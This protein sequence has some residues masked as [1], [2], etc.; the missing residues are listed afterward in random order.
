M[1]IKPIERTSATIERK[2]ATI[3]RQPAS[4][5]R[6]KKLDISEIMEP[7]ESDIPEVDGDFLDQLEAETKAVVDSV[8]ADRAEFREFVAQLNDTKFYISVVFQSESQKIDFLQKAGLLDI[9]DQ[10]NYDNMFVSGLE[11]ARRLGYPVEPIEL[12]D[13]KLRGNPSKYRKEVISNVAKKDD[14]G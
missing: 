14:P 10:H 7:L 11:V 12:T 2:A 9:N 6:G 4:I 1:P 3:Q 8:R 13:Y 5:W